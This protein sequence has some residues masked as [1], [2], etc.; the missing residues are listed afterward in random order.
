LSLAS[1][2][3]F[4]SEPQKPAFG[5]D[6]PKISVPTRAL[7][8]APAHIA[9]GSSVTTIVVPSRRQSP[10]ASAAWRMAISSA[11]P[12]RSPDSRR[13]LPRPIICPLLSTMTAHR[14]LAGC[15]GPFREREGFRHPLS[16]IHRHGFY[17]GSA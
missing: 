15:A 16:L 2:T 1:W 14:N 5:S 9:H 12:S 11:W 4:P 8:S 10:M 7:T 13:L 17:L 6:A 3:R